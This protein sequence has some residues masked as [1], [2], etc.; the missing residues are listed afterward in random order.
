MQLNDLKTHPVIKYA[1]YFGFT[2]IIISFVFFYGWSS[3]STQSAAT[4]QA[5]ARYRST[6]TMSFLPW[7]K[8]DL[9]LTGE[10]REAAGV[11]ANRKLALLGPQLASQFT[12]LGIRP[13]SLATDEEAVQQAVDDRMLLREAERLDMYVSRNEIIEVLNAAAFKVPPS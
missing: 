11:V 6:E 4:S 13:E 9:I 12:L 2:L 1:A 8:W 7:R 5:Y 3:S 10:V